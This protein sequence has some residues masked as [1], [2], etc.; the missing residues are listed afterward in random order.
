MN[1]T[2]LRQWMIPRLPRKI[3][4]LT[5]QSKLEQQDYRIDVRTIQRDLNKLSR[6]LPLIGDEAR[7][8]GWSWRADAKA[9]DVPALDPQEALAFQNGGSPPQTFVADRYPELSAP[10]LR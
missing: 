2:L 1:D 8:Q 5:L 3:D 7:P 6:A 9:L 10:V 4:T